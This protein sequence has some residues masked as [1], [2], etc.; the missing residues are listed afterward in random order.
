MC[1]LRSHN[2]FFWKH[3]TKMKRGPKAQLCSKEMNR[4]GQI[5]SVP[6]PAMQQLRIWLLELKEELEKIREQLQNIE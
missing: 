6:N 2:K 5:P 3:L 1:P 4:E